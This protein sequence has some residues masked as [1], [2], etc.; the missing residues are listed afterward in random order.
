M[1]NQEMNMCI[2]DTGSLSHKI[3]RIHCNYSTN[4]AY[5][6]LY[7]DLKSP[8]MSPDN[9]DIPAKEHNK[10]RRKKRRIK[11]RFDSL[12]I[13]YYVYTYIF[14]FPIFLINISNN[15]Q[16]YCSCYDYITIYVMTIFIV[17]CQCI[18][19]INIDVYNVYIGYVCVALWFLFIPIEFRY[20]DVPHFILTL[21]SL[22]LY[23][24]SISIYIGFWNR[25]HH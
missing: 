13:Y 24:I 19:T 6:K 16:F 4:L 23:H 12:A 20:S 1:E 5:V 21:L 14:F 2:Y 15:H 7:S 11:K 8:W 9:N 10:N 25:F 22:P 17:N 18:A 3:Y